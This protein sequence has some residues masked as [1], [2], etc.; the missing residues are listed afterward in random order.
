VESK[1]L[2][3]D[4]I[5]EIKTMLC[6]VGGDFGQSEYEK[7]R[8]AEIKEKL[9]ATVEELERLQYIEFRARQEWNTPP[10]G[11]PLEAVRSVQRWIHTGEIIRY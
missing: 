3:E 6:D 8:I 7:R 4:D 2:T 11:T 1:I 5:A 9:D 10:P